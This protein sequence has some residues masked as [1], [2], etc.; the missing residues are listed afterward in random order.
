MRVKNENPK[1]KID[2]LVGGDIVLLSETEDAD[3]VD[4]YALVIEV[5]ETGNDKV[6]YADLDSGRIYTDVENYPILQIFDKD[7]MVFKIVKE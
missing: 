6:A 7:N 4:W 3:S 5:G 1:Y 2:D